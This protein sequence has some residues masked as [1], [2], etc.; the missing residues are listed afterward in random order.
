MYV[1]NSARVARNRS[2]NGTRFGRRSEERGDRTRL[3]Q[4][5]GGVPPVVG[6]EDHLTRRHDARDHLRFHYDPLNGPKRRTSSRQD[7]RTMEFSHP[8]HNPPRCDLA[9]EQHAG[10]LCLSSSSCLKWR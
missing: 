8:K 5:D 6:D 1:L 2:E 3:A 4:V 10:L 7:I 9:V